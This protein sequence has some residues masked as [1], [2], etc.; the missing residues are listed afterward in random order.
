MNKPLLAGAVGALAILATFAKTKTSD[1]VLMTVNGKDVP[2]SEFEYLY[3]KNNTQQLQP[4]TLDEYVDMFVT[5][6]LKVADAEAAGID[7]TKAFIDEFNGYR[8][9]LAAPYLTDNDYRDSLLHVSYDRMGHNVDVSHIMVSLVNEDGE[10]A[11]Q[12][13]LLDSLRQ[14]IVAGADFT[15]LAKKY[16]ADAS[17]RNNGGHLGYISANQYPIEFEDVAYATAEGEV[18]PVFDTRFGHHIIKRGP[19]R[20]SPGEVHVRHILK[21][22]RGL[23]A[24]QARE[25]K[26][27][28]DS[29]YTLLQN[30]AD[31]AMLA[32]TES[33]DPGSARNGGDLP[34][35]GPG[36]M[37]AEFENM[38]F[39]LP[40][41]A[42]SAPFATPFGYH[43]V[44]RLAHKGIP[45]FD[46]AKV[47]LEKAFERDNRNERIAQRNIEKFEKIYP[48]KRNDKNLAEVRQMIEAAGGIDSTLRAQLAASKL[49]AYTTDGRNVTVGNV[50]AGIPAKGVAGAS[51]GCKM[52]DL[53]LRRSIEVNTMETARKRLAQQNIDYKHL[54]GEYR[55]GILLYEISNRNVWDRATKDTEGL[56][57]F[58]EANRDNYTWQQPHY[59]G[60]VVMA[61]TDSVADLARKF[62]DGTNYEGDSL[63]TTLRKEFGKDVK[64]ERVVTAKGDNA[65]VDY[66][67]FGGPRPLEKRGRSHWNAWF[68]YNG[69][70]IEQPEE[71]ND[72]KGVVSTDYHQLLEKEWVEKLHNTY[73]VKINQKVLQKVK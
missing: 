45:S 11:P 63:A 43:I 2:L 64:V 73:P 4:Q 47:N 29:I 23:N 9:E 53:A 54:L 40:D 7:T 6:K 26:A 65:I 41:S 35:F 27:Q 72:V 48:A 21:M 19:E 20:N 33:E 66:V 55:D 32:R 31:F 24:E 58:F 46:E 18:S 59:K 51:E 3:H 12:V 37:V 57:R 17:V 28:I 61:T 62:L 56:A 60:Y 38:S 15:E 52:F 13:A 25:K 44:Q 1:P 34:W 70:I 30:G 36:R 42:I 14:L 39:S 8:N 22:T 50:A 71:V 69:R 49:V 5:Y 16:S 67:A 10:S 68:A